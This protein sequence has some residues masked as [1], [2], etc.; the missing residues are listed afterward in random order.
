MEGGVFAGT[1]TLEGEATETRG[2]NT[3]GGAEDSEII[4]SP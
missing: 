4:K 1:I 2:R 3:E